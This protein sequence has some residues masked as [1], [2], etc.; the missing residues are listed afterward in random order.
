MALLLAFLGRA[1]N[2]AEVERILSMARELGDPPVVARALLASGMCSDHDPTLARQYFS[3]AAKIARDLG[4]PPMLSQ[5]LAQ[6][7][8]S[9]CIGEGSVAHARVA[10]AEGLAIADGIGD[11]FVAR[12]A[13]FALGWVQWFSGDLSG[14]A[15]QFSALVDEAGSARDAMFSMYSLEMLAYT[16]S[17]TGDGSGARAAAEE[18]LRHA[19][20]LFEYY[21]GTVYTAVAQA[22]LAAGDAPAAARAFTTARN[23]SGLDLRIA[24]TFSWAAVASLASGDLS[25][26]RRWADEVVP[27]TR[28]L[29][30]SLSLTSRAYVEIAHGE[31]DAAERD[32]CDGLDLAAHLGGDIIIPFALDC[33]AMVAGD[34]GN[35]LQAARLF[36]A[37][38]AA[39]QRM[40][41][42]R[43]PALDGDI[44]ARIAAV[45]HALGEND[46]DATWVEGAALSIEEATRCALGGRTTRKRAST[47][48]DSLTPAEL[49]VVRLVCE[50]LG[51]KDVATRLFISP[52][53]VQAHLT[54]VYTKLGLTSRMQLAQ[55]AAANLTG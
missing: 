21:E 27:A 30:R 18:A 14:A 22:H 32:A 50:G 3:E 36:G 1:E 34:A 46:F 20:E 47:G 26:A 45:R 11:G 54:H 49:D 35:H 4:D 53:T 8:V 52:R 6:Q 41:V 10:A 15:V 16:L 29:G 40:G 9:T 31:P 2:N 51:N 19:S 33:L 48:W 38:D 43:F 42:M 13:R 25:A 28:G 39:R 24:S 12:Q 44:E 23:R 5:I 55:M 37:A 7:A 17:Y